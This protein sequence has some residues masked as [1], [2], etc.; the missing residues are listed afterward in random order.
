V[1]VAAPNKDLSLK[2]GMTATTRIIVDERAD[3]LRLP[4]QGLRYVPGGLIGV[5]NAQ[6]PPDGRRR[7]GL[8]VA[9]RR[10]RAR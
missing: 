7:Q 10:F 5:P 3:A 6:T 4:D 9:R 2:P 8:G 1:V